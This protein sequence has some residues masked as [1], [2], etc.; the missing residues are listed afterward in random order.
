MLLL[1]ME[2]YF[3]HP[4]YIHIC[5]KFNKNIDGAYV[6]SNCKHREFSIKAEVVIRVGRCDECTL[7]KIDRMSEAGY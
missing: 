5:H 3:D 4:K 2:M 1:G 6:C 7:V